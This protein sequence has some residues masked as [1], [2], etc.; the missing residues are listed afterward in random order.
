VCLPDGALGALAR[1]DLGVV[2]RCTLLDEEA[3]YPAVLGARPDH[4]HVGEGGVADPLLLPVQ[5]VAAVAENGGR[6][7]GAGVAPGTRL[8][9][10]E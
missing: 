2:A 9:E 8:G 4:D 10:C 6:R 1:E 5:D 7:Q 3:P